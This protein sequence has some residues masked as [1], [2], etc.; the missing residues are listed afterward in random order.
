[1]R[2]PNEAGAEPGSNRATK[3]KD[4]RKMRPQQGGVKPI[5]VGALVLPPKEA[6]Q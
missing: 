6:A 2:P 1:M 5:A 3:T 4:T